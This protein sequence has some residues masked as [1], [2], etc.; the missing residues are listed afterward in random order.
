MKPSYG[1]QE[2]LE[3]GRSTLRYSRGNE[4][5]LEFLFP[6]LRWGE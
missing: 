5:A 4:A 6:Y 3:V 2:K 1:F